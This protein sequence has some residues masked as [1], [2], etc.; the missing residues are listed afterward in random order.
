MGHPRRRVGLAHRRLSI[1]DLDAGAQPMTDGA[2]NWIAFNGEIYNYLELREELGAEQFRT[3]SD[4]EVI[5]RAYARWGADASTSCAACSPSRSGTKRR[6]RSSAPAT[7]SASSRSTTPQVDDV[8]YFASEAKALLPFLPAIETDPDG[9]KDYLTFQFCLAGKTL[10]KGVRRAAAR[11]SC[12]RPGRRVA[13][14]GATGRSTTTSTS[15]TP[16]STSRSSCSELLDDSVDIH[17]RSDVPIGA[18]VSGGLDSSIVASLASQQAAGDFDGFTGKFI[19]SA[20]LRREPLCARPSRRT[21]RFPR[22]TRSTSRPQ[23]FIDNIRKV[24]YHLDY[25]VAGPGLVPAVHGLA[26]GQHSI[27]RSCSAARAAMRSSAAMR[28]I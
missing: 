12:S 3:D 20:E 16:R 25:P 11:P 8:L 19:V 1:I 15:T 13:A 21:R 10:F 22:C 27:A 17:M 9:L 4:T 28:A 5:L 7:A 24:I 14:R 18:Y 6:R 26:A 2:G 23:D